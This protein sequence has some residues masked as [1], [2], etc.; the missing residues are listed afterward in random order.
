MCR[1]CARGANV[2]T[3]RARAR[4]R[5]GGTCSY[6]WWVH[7]VVNLGCQTFEIQ[8][9]FLPK[10]EIRIYFYELKYRIYLLDKYHLLRCI[11]LTLV[12]VFSLFTHCNKYRIYF[13]IFEGGP[14]G[15]SPR[16]H[17]LDMYHL[18]W[19]ISL[20]LVTV[21]SL[22]TYCNKYQTYFYSYLFKLIK[23]GSQQ[24]ATV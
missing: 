9:I 4:A 18:L 16:H 21:F 2:T 12:T 8:P 17:L 13:Y 10:L 15:A 14:G 6:V 20:T 3:R 24:S 7:V 19:W 5:V 11:S 23:A 1:F 22:I